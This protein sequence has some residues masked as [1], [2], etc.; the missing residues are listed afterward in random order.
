V[1]ALKWAR[2]DEFR[3]AKETSWNNNAG[4][5]RQVGPFTW[6]QVYNAGHMVPMD[7]PKAALDMLN[8]FLKGQMKQDL[9]VEEA[10]RNSMDDDL[11]D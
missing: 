7:Q 11:E 1:L 8:Q 9:I 5:I 2:G 6:L 4:L 10:I 3:A